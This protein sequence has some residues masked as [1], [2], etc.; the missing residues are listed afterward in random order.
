MNMELVT[1]AVV[2]PITS[3]LWESNKTTLNNKDCIPLCYYLPRR[4]EGALGKEQVKAPFP[5]VW[6]QTAPST[7][8]RG[9]ACSWLLSAGAYSDIS[10]YLLSAL[11][12]HVSGDSDIIWATGAESLEE[13]GGVWSSPA[14]SGST[15]PPMHPLTLSQAACKSHD[16]LSESTSSPF[17]P[18]ASIQN[19]P[20]WESSPQLNLSIWYS[21]AA[22]FA[23]HSMPIHCV[24]TQPPLSYLPSSVLCPKMKWQEGLFPMH[25]MRNCCSSM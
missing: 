23:T 19:S 16:T 18:Q 12:P 10:S 3:L 8:W 4:R 25:W 13:T 9:P 2:L 15:F 1:S 11:W 20:A 6:C 21:L 7:L 22:S 24:L 17:L 14:H 5:P